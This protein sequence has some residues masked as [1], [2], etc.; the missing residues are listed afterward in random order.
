[1]SYSGWTS[2]SPD[3]L[4]LLPTRLA[5]V[6]TPWS[7]GGHEDDGVVAALVSSWGFSRSR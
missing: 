1:M 3:D 7:L 5:N 2:A 6:S 4:T